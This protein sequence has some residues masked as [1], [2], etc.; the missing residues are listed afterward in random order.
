MFF[1]KKKK[2]KITSI[3]E[4]IIWTDN[5]S[6]IVRAKD[7]NLIIE[8]RFFSPMFNEEFWLHMP[9]SERRARV[10]EEALKTVLIALD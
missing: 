5:K 2:K 3:G 7:K 9:E 8:E 1:R 10:L 6:R 4:D